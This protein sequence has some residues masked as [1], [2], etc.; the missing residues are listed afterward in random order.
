MTSPDTP[1]SILGG[2]RNPHGGWEETSA[3]N[4]GILGL[5]DTENSNISEILNPIRSELENMQMK[6]DE[7][8]LSEAELLQS[9]R[10]INE[11]ESCELITI[12]NMGILHD[13]S[14]N[15]FIVDTSFSKGK[16]KAPVRYFTRL[17]ISN[18]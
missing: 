1:E 15:T 2:Y 14:A 11:I 4:I 3:E 5:G 9:K 17:N 7:N 8:S 12:P 18:T 16:K 6:S 10:K 13:R